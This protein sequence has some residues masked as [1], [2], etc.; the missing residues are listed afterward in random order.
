MTITGLQ[1]PQL[2]DGPGLA[3]AVQSENQNGYVSGLVAHAGGTQAA[4]LKLSQ[5]APLVEVDTVATGG[6]SVLLPAAIPGSKMFI[7]NNGAASMNVFGLLSTDTIN[8]VTTAFAIAIQTG[9]V[10]WC[11]KS[12]SWCGH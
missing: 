11:A 10:F 4:G 1:N 7:F 2:S 12:G 6:D 5:L 8:N 9:A 3:L